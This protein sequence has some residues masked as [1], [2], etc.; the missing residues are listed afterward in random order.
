MSSRHSSDFK[1]SSTSD[2]E[3][4]QAELSRASLLKA[5]LENE[6]MHLVQSISPGR[7]GALSGLPNELLIEI[8]EPVV[9]ANPIHI[10]RLMLVCRAW[11]QVIKSTPQLWTTIRITVPRM[12]KAARQCAS[13]CATC[14]ERSKPFPLDIDIHYTSFQELPQELWHALA[15][16]K[17]IPASA[18]TQ[19]S[20]HLDVLHP[21]WSVPNFDRVHKFWESPE[22][23]LF[24]RYCREQYLAPLRSLS[25]ERF[26]IMRR[27][28]SFGVTSGGGFESY[29]SMCTRALYANLFGGPTPLLE[30]LRIEDANCYDILALTDSRPL[31]FP[32]LPKIQELL[33]LNVAI[34]LNVSKIDSTRLTRLSL[35]HF[36]IFQRDFLLCCTN[37]VEL[38]VGDIRMYG[39]LYAKPI[40]NN[41]I[42]FP[43]LRR[44]E[45]GLSLPNWFWKS[46]EFPVLD[47]VVF[48]TGHAFHS[49][50]I[51]ALPPSVTRVELRYFRGPPGWKFALRNLV[52]CPL[53]RTI[54]CPRQ[55][56]QALQTALQAFRDEGVAD[57]PFTTLLIV[58]F[59]HDTDPDHVEVVNID[60]DQF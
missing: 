40:P 28:R 14:V 11:S 9:A 53:L 22:D 8:F 55:S 50:T 43:Q 13:Y 45:L 16:V 44:L 10:G 29:G 12:L 27:W 54:L 3:L 4:L 17:L 30:R 35:H 37:V 25:G 46:I 38:R 58:P 5:T 18:I 59:R 56:S 32:Y 23:S 21:W 41:P 7:C 26:S 60:A 34:P 47:I 24:K 6:I 36:D 49:V 33:L 31:A 1:L 39:G 19:P 57:W 15:A 48:E 42:I 2:V 20:T 51:A 52:C